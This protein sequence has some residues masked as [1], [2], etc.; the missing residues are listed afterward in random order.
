MYVLTIYFFTLPTSKKTIYL[1][2]KKDDRF[3]KL[4][5][6]GFLSYTKHYL[7]AKYWQ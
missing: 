5:Q 1:K 4:H 2:K 3:S 6:D 7:P